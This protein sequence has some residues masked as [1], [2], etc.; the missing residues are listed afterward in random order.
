[1]TGDKPKRN[2]RKIV[3]TVV[4]T[5]VLTCGCIC[6]GIFIG[7]KLNVKKIA[8]DFTI[9]EEAEESA[10]HRY[11]FLTKQVS[12]YICNLCTELEIDPNLAVGILMAENPEFNA[13][14]IHK[15]AN[16][17]IDCGLFQLNDR[18]IWTSFQKDYWFDNL[19][20][21]PFNWKH[22]T[23]LALHHLNYLRKHLKVTE[24]VI[25]AYNCGINSVMNN[26]IPAATKA[27]LAKVKNNIFLL[28]ENNRTATE[29]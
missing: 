17:T 27:Y 25:M 2:V 7:G 9:P 22:N 4:I 26:K 3:L 13:D 5:W 29:N 8:V 10:E 23:Y 15:N 12:D 11:P 16:G 24:D 20:L 1:M 18:Y 14:A 28:E 19:E 6:L 21:D